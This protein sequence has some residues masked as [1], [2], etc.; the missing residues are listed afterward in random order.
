MDGWM[1]RWMG[2]ENRMTSNYLKNLSDQGNLAVG[3]KYTVNET[4]VYTTKIC[5]NLF[6]SLLED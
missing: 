3:N 5:P 6:C 4:N 1:D 2:K